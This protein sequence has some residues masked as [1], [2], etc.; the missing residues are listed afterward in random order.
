M[1]ASCRGRRPAFRGPI[2]FSLFPDAIIREF[3]FDRNLLICRGA[4]NCGGP[5]PLYIPFFLHRFRGWQHVTI[6]CAFLCLI[7]PILDNE[8]FL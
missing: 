6:T 5:A 4:I 2:G 1:R 8:T 7:E 3:C